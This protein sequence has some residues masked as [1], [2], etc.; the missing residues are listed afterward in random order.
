M[1]SAQTA[2]RAV[3]V[4]RRMMAVVIEV[5]GF[6]SS[7]SSSCVVVTLSGL[8]QEPSSQ[9]ALLFIGAVRARLPIE[10][11]IIDGAVLGRMVLRPAGT[12][13]TRR[14]W[15]WCS[16]VSDVP[17]AATATAT[18]LMGDDVNTFV[19][20][21]SDLSENGLGRGVGVCASTFEDSAK[22]TLRP[23]SRPSAGADSPFSAQ[24]A[25]LG[26]VAL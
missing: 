26:V 1:N 13:L 2:T 5:W 12:V 25:L 17:A 19:T 21:R 23:V 18:G 3:E 20:G 4:R 16:F 10:I 22:S 8:M 6:A 14:M 24:L 11:G 7:S 15:L 9:P